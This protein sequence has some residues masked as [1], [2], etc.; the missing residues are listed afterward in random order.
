MKLSNVSAK[1]LK[2]LKYFPKILFHWR[3]V[4]WLYIYCPVSAF[5]EELIWKSYRSVT[6]RGSC[7][8]PWNMRAYRFMV[9]ILWNI[10]VQIRHTNYRKKESISL[11][12]YLSLKFI[13]FNYNSKALK[14]Y[15]R[16]WN[17]ILFKLQ[18]RNIYI[19]I[20]LLEF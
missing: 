11:I 10:T 9:Y 2:T 8:K 17:T 16:N 15:C 6:I 7:G 18:L 12:K 5:F 20:I 4:L 13:V 19:F 14:W 1:I 3:Q